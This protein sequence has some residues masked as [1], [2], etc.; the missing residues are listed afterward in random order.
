MVLPASPLHFSAAEAG[1][2]S[3]VFLSLSLPLSLSLSLMLCG[4]VI[5]RPSP[6][7][8][9]PFLLD[10][11]LVY[12]NRNTFFASVIV[13]CHHM[14]ECTVKAISHPFTMAGGKIQNSSLK[15][16][17][18]VF[19]HTIIKSKHKLKPRHKSLKIPTIT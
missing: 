8:S 3:C 7:L 4:G 12:L 17:M 5:E 14:R 19:R 6:S 13:S 15:A 1:A 2:S 16:E 9:P 18:D 10:V 11:V